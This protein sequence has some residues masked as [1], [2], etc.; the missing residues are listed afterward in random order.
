MF[1]IIKKKKKTRAH[2]SFIEYFYFAR[3]IHYNTYKLYRDY[4]IKIMEVFYSVDK[5]CA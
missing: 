5:I 2:F 3:R 4:Q 1:Y